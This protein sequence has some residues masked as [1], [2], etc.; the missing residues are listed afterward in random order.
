MNEIARFVH[1][2]VPGGQNLM[3]E[4]LAEL[5]D[6]IA[7]RTELWRP[8]VRHD[9]ERR[10]WHQ[11]YRDPNLDV[12]L[13]CWEQRQD[14]GYHDHDLSCGAVLV[15]E[16][17]LLEDYFYRRDDGWVEERTRERAAG[18]RWDF[19]S[20]SIHGLRN[21]YETPATS[22]HCYSP[23]LWRMG[24]Y[25]PGPLGLRREPITYADEVAFA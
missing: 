10:I 12:W 14:T 17:T 4:Q 5:A 21:A 8:L 7:D 24:Y 2:R 9:P 20:S 15:V 6:A 3:R 13:I 18:S 22:I 23:A 11:L 16:G 25:H 19:D 1:A